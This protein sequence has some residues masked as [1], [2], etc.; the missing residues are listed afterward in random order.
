M[1]LKDHL[2]KH[3]FIL[4]TRNVSCVSVFLKLCITNLVTLVLNYLCFACAHL[5]NIMFSES[6]LIDE[7]LRAWKIKSRLNWQPNKLGLLECIGLDNLTYCRTYSA[8]PSYEFICAC[9][10]P[11]G[12]LALPG[13]PAAPGRPQPD[14]LAGEPQLPR[15][16]FLLTCRISQHCEE[17]LNIAKSI[18]TW[19][20][21]LH[22]TEYIH[23]DKKSPHI[24]KPWRIV[25]I[26]CSLDIFGYLVPAC[27]FL[28]MFMLIWYLLRLK[29]PKMPLKRPKTYRN[30]YPH[31]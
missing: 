26:S 8:P 21:S 2:Q 30:P 16:V 29:E 3:T 28:G 22:N 4:P 11:R 27:R 9:P 7:E 14:L 15:E 13:L 25:E 31:W 20:R 1:K 24:L 19:R 18:S 23:I 12:N 5:T 17:Y 10:W 6:K